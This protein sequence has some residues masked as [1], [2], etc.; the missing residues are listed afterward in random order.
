M[1]SLT[2]F[3]GSS[4]FLVFFLL[5]IVFK[6]GSA[7]VAA[8]RASLLALLGWAILL[9]LGLIFIVFFNQLLIAI[10]RDGI[11]GAMVGIILMTLG[12][13]IVGG[14]AI[15]F[16]SAI[17]AGVAGVV[18]KLFDLFFWVLHSLSKGCER[19]CAK[20]LSLIQTS[21]A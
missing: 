15:A 11:A 12:T 5:G 19:I 4:I 7:M 6:M 2:M 13:A 20:M 16:G 21:A 8:L 14:V 18:G 17:M 10:R 1:A 9:I 3:W